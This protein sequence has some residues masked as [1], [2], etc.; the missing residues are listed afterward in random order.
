MRKSSS[1]R[2]WLQRQC[3][4]HFVKQAQNSHY[5]SRAR[6][7]LLDIQK[8]DKLIKPGMCVIDL[9]CT[10]GGWSELAIELVGEQGQVIAVDLCEMQAIDG[11]LFKQGDFRD[12]AFIAELIDMLQARHVDVVLSDMAPNFMGVRSVD[13][14][15]CIELSEQ[16]LYFASCLLTSDGAF[17]TKTFQGEG[18]EDLLHLLKKTFKKIVI[19]KPTASRAQSRE[20]YLLARGR[21]DSG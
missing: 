4:D 21:L 16:A 12:P 11:V 9:G 13:Q 6:F 10:P 1:S 8:R 5:R 7:K 14:Q 19:R 20:V 15:R 17:L 3:K 2:R 18:F